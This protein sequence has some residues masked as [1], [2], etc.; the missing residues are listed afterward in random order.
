MFAFCIFI[1][2]DYVFTLHHRVTLVR[3]DGEVGFIAPF[4]LPLDGEFAYTLTKVR[5]A[6]SKLGSF[7]SEPFRGGGAGGLGC[8]L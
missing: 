8:G 4:G 3:S 6:S 5:S 2:I 7:R 1:F